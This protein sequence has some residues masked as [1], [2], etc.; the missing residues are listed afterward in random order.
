LE[1]VADLDAGRVRQES[2]NVHELQQALQHLQ[3]RLRQGGKL[4]TSV[5]LT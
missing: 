5:R 4:Q 3:Q 1:V 2:N